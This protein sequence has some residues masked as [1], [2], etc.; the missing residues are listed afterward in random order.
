M[1]FVLKANIRRFPQNK[2]KEIEKEIAN[3]EQQQQSL[4]HDK[5]LLESVIMEN[6]QKI[7]LLKTQLIHLQTQYRKSGVN[8][9]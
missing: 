2:N 4:E 9:R 6:K 5:V 1:F 3:I 7:V 8:V